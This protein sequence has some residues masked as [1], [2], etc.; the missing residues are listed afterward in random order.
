MGT[1]C[2]QIADALFMR[3]NIKVPCVCLFHHSG[4]KFTFENC[5]KM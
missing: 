3:T 5:Q 2:E 4:K 1:L